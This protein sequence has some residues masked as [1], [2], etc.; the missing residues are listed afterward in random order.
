MGSGCKIETKYSFRA[1]RHF[2]ASWIIEQAFIPKRVQELMDHS[3]LQMT[4]ETHG[5]L[6]PTPEDDHKKLS[7]AEAPF[8]AF[9]LRGDAGNARKAAKMAETRGIHWKTKEAVR[10]PPLTGQPNDIIE[11]P[12]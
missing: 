12:W 8:A 4:Y 2:Y 9:L 1:L 5:H 3:S 6:F 11:T 10:R 7:Q